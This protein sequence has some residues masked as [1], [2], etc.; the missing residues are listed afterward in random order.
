MLL[1]GRV[2]D[3][4]LSDDSFKPSYIEKLSRFFII[5]EVVA[6][7]WLSH[8]DSF[9]NGFACFFMMVHRNRDAFGSRFALMV[10]LSAI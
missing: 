3:Y 10:A 9:S 2:Y 5:Y 8:F 7:D 6:C 4:C 1:V